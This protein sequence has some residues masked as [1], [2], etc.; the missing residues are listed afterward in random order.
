MRENRASGRRPAGAGCGWALW[1]ACLLFATTAFPAA[2]TPEQL[3]QVRAA[4]FEVVV[5]KNEPTAVKYEKPL[6]MELVPYQVRNDL[7]WS[8]GTAFQIAPGR[9]ASAAHVVTS[10]IGSPFG[11]LSLRDAAGRIYPVQA[12]E[13][14]SEGEDFAVFTVAGAPTASLPTSIDYHMDSPV[15]AVGNALGEGVIARDGLLTSM[16]PEALE[17]RWKWLRFSAAT[18]PGNSG[19]PLLD[20][21][22]RIIGLVIGKS[23]NENLNYALPIDRLLDNPGKVAR[24]ENR[25]AFPWAILRDPFTYRFER[26]S[27]LPMSVADFG[28]W[29]LAVNSQFFAEQRARLQSDPAIQLFPQGDSAEVLATQFMALRPG[30]IVQ[31]RDL[32]WETQQGNNDDDVDLPGGGKV[33]LSDVGSQVSLFRVSDPTVAGARAVD[34]PTALMDSVLKAMR[35]PRVVGTQK[36]RVTS[37]GP[38][39]LEESFVDR[40]GRRWRS[41]V[42]TLGYLDLSFVLSSV[43]TPD[44]RMGLA[45]L[46]N[47]R[48]VRSVLDNLQ[49]V[50][51]FAQLSFSGTL[52]QW[53]AYLAARDLAPKS[54]ASLQWKHG[55]G[56]P[57]HVQ[58]P[59]FTLDVPTEVVPT[60]DQSE[61]Q[62]LTS[63]V[64]T[65]GKLDWEITGVEL[66]RDEDAKT[67]MRVARQLK[68]APGAGKDLLKRWHE[69]LTLTGDFAPGLGRDTALKEF[70]L[71]IVLP[72]RDP[73]GAEPAE[74]YDVLYD[75]YE[76][77][78]PR[79]L[80]EVGR[81]LPTIL[82]VRNP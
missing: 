23:E 21:Q 48:Q 25:G 31:G 45:S 65:N 41:Q 32:A 64:L 4:T 34:A 44:G 30:L 73:A 22:G 66:R 55:D 71:R 6:P 51:N 26:E 46:G 81:L 24:I 67:W 56:K 49:L 70:W 59:R 80:D 78:L 63:Y 58:V 10:A 11:P 29:V 12:V 8:I 50:A 20:E 16:T 39:V 62:L 40:F 35:L 60:T 3:Q 68:P 7:Y 19:G 2:L 54:F 37:L 36:I 5:A 74:L 9:F 1:C 52:P 28:K 72:T 33:W 38:P 42:W 53:E 77:R 75:T 57:F 27:P 43:A 15:F 76:P 69:M 17:G 79:E 13:K 18:S 14:F 82:K 47:G 61:L